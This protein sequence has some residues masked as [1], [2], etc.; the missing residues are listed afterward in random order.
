MLLIICAYNGKNPSRSVEG[1]KWTQL[2]YRQMEWN[3][4]HA[5]TSNFLVCVCVCGGGGGGGVEGYINQY[6]Y[7]PAEDILH[8]HVVLIQ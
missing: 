8:N 2:A 6:L 7:D 5:P 1:V 3:Q 4:Y